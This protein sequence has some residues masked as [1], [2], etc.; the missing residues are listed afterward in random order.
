MTLN[1]GTVRFGAI[2]VV[3]GLSSLAPAQTR[4][5]AK[6]GPDIVGRI[7]FDIDSQSGRVET[8]EVTIGDGG[9]GPYKAILTGDA[10][11]P[12]HAIYRPRDLK[13]FSKAKPLP[14]VAHGNG[15]C[16]NTSGEVRNFLSDIAS[17]GFLVIA[18]GPPGNALVMGSEERT[19]TTASTQL[20]D[21]VSW[22]I[23][24]NDRPESG[25][26]QKV[27]VSKVAVM[28]Q[29]CGAQQAV[30][31]SLDPRVTTT[32][33]LNQGV[34][35]TPRPVGAAPGGGGGRGGIEQRRDLRYAPHAPNMMRAPA[36]PS[37][38]TPLA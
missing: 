33:A 32:I 16:R 8:M 23:A 35:M 14:I 10:T 31:V 24:Q 4:E 37:A 26:Y 15:G 11:L 34:N 1:I 29:S 38:L 3:M 18:V 6:K 9:S 12:T 17:Q 28:G 30:D 7:D 5:P 25:L 27:D 2:A 20:L 36:D 22:A 19:N 21:A 13:P